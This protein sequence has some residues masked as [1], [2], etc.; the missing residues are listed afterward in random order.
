MKDPLKPKGG[1]NLQKAVTPPQPTAQMPQQTAK[2]MNQQVLPVAPSPDDLPQPEVG[3]SPDEIARIKAKRQAAPQG[4]VK[5][6][7]PNRVGWVRRWVNDEPGRL[8]LMRNKGWEFVKN[9]ST[10]ENWMIV[11]D[12]KITEKGGRKG[13]VM[14]IPLQFYAEDQDAKSESLDEVEKAIYG[15]RH[16]EEPDDKRYVPKETPIEVKTRVGRG[17]G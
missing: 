10:G 1:A 15:G 14:E 17:S 12:R 5:L 9:P 6:S 3:P 8:E 13:Y 4:Q 2:A 11:V 16:N 7:I